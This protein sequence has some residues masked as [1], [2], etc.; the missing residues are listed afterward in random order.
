MACAGP[1]LVNTQTNSYFLVFEVSFW[2]SL[3]AWDLSCGLRCPF[4]SAI[5]ILAMYNKILAA[6][7]EHLNSEVTA[8]YALHLAR[9]CNPSAACWIN[10]SSTPADPLDV[11]ASRQSAAVA[12]GS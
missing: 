8:R 2:D 5:L 10:S 3:L 11:A 12:F 9:A 7:N 6:V 1:L 4:F